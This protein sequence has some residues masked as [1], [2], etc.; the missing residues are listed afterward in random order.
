M[1]FRRLFFLSACA[2]S[3]R[4]FLFS[5]SHE[6]L[7]DFVG[8]VAEGALHGALPLRRGAGGS[9]G[10][11]VQDMGFSDMVSPSTKSL[12]TGYR[13]APGGKFVP[14]GLAYQFYQLIHKVKSA[15][16]IGLSP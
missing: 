6:S 1:N 5:S 10:R 4:L 11:T 13:L 2:S 14:T 8:I 7:G 15:L 12:S 9:T 3:L 16:M